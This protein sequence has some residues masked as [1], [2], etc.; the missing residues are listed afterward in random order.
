MEQTLL[1]NKDS[2]NESARA[3]KALFLTTLSF[4]VCF[5]CWVI[6]AMLVTY[7][8]QNAIF[9][10]SAQ[11]VGWLI[12]TPIL[13]G[14]ISRVPLGILTDKHGGRI[15]MTILMLVCALPMFL[16][17]QASSFTGFL[18]CSLGFGL[19]G[20]GFAV[21][22]GYVSAW[23]P[24]EKQGT[25]LGI[26]GMGNAGA[27][28]TSLAAPQL[29]TYL[30]KNSVPA[31]SWQSLPQIY[32]V[33]L[34]ITALVFFIG[35]ESRLV[36]DSSEKSLAQRLE[37]L[38]SMIVW[39]FGLYYALLFGS[40]V[41]MSQWL[42]PYTVN[43]YQI[44]LAQAGVLAAVFSLPSGIIRALGGW[45]SD[46]Y[47]ARALMYTVFMGCAISCA[48]LSI[49]KMDIF[50]P[51]VGISSKQSGTVFEVGQN[52]IVI[53]DRTYEVNPRPL[54][55]AAE[56]DAETNSFFLPKLQT[57]QQPKVEVG[58]IV[59]KDQ[60][61]ASGVSNLY[62]PANFWI[63][64]VL[65]FI[66]GILTGVGKAGVFKFIP[67]HFP[68]DVGTV[69][70]IVGLIGAMGGFILPMVF[71]VLLG[72]TG[73]WATCWIVLT[74]LSIVCLIWMQINI[75]RI[76]EIE[77]P[78]LAKLIESSSHRLIPDTVD[79]RSHV[80]TNVETLLQGLPFFH[81]LTH[82]ELHSVA[83]IGE[84]KSLG[85]G[86]LV[87]KQGDPGDALYV[88][89]TG[90]VEIFLI[91][92]DDQQIDLAELGDGS[93]F[94][95]LALIDGQ[96]RSASARTIEVCEFFLVGRKQFLS[97]MTDSPRILADVL[98]GLS[99]HI[100][101][102]NQRY[103]DINE[104]KERLQIQAELDRHQS[105]AEMVAGVAH[106]INTPLGIVNH[107]ASIITEE[108]N[109]K[110]IEEI[111]KDEDAE[112]VLEGVALAARLIQDN[113]SRADKLITSF[114]NLSVRQIVDQKEEIRISEVIDDVLRLYGLKAQASNLGLEFENQLG[115][116]DVWDG[117]P[118]P[119]SQI[120]L[121][122]ISNAD[123]YAY[124]E[125]G[126]GRLDVL[127]KSAGP[128]NPKYDYIISL[129]DYGVGIKDE[130]KEKV[131][132]AFY[133]TGRSIGG[134]GIG[135]SVVY[136]LVT[137]QLD[138]N[139]EVDS[140]LGEG[141]QFIIYLPKIVKEKQQQTHLV[142]EIQKPT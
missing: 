109:S 137:F 23:F 24:S 75:S 70:G 141:S 16:L 4:S 43:V 18:L 65:V 58:D 100:R 118:G 2:Q 57:W 85:E 42:V 131:F 111:A 81:D 87:F 91:G 66:F 77:V 133:T 106:E 71:S 50:T 117:Y 7:L 130:D 96:P 67:D 128:S 89:I 138:G 102:T 80:P 94:G 97:L 11:Q 73:I 13:T 104:K 38:K 22:A 84:F 92:E 47:G 127:L 115:E 139:V 51:G 30:S 93:Y 45:L 120:L 116:E 54:A 64:A 99:E 3:N 32:A 114:K 20:G 21:G 88:V 112:E 40:F 125:G 107:A 56:I 110:T 46:R 83:Q 48:L 140:T 82:E 132:E 74:I 122:I 14:A 49:P 33:V 37:P 17:S 6:N 121:N 27:A 25:V 63:F 60:L 44:S 95:D 55:L 29:L 119:L 101:N 124:P 34:V 10:F 72:A 79:Y 9:E 8:V 78:N 134:S 36:A 69:A 142:K 5:A 26:F 15:I 123:R 129:N 76:M 31:E 39:R 135:L 59:T 62:Y 53:S 136:N 61:I 90:K 126:G 86:E 108:V 103:V 98:I 105:I 41:A 28:I 113:I 52:L 19:C 68:N 35:S 1:Q 12:A